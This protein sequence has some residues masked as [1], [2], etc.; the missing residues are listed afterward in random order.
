MMLAALLLVDQRQ[1]ANAHRAQADLFRGDY[2]GALKES[3]KVTRPPAEGPI[4]LTDAIALTFLNRGAEANRA[5]SLAA[6]RDPDNWRLRHLWA[7]V[8][9]ALGRRQEASRQMSE[10]KRLNPTLRLPPS[11]RPSR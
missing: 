6:D 3:A 11:F 4:L 10:A 2:A 5:F 8:L 7:A 1:A 9:L